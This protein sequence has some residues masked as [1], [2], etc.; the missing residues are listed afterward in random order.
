VP[1][2]MPVTNVSQIERF[3]S[4][5]GATIPAR[6]QKRLESVR[7][8]EDAVVKTGIDWATEQCSQLLEGGAPGIHF[9]TLNKSVASRAVHINLNGSPR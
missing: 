1:G 7:E 3:T 8:D 5:C 9:F 2:V 6:L 4:I